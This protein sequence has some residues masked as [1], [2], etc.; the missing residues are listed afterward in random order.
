MIESIKHA[1][2]SFNV[3]FITR[4]KKALMNR[5]KKDIKALKKGESLEIVFLG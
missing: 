4:S 1:I 3:R 2:K 5:V